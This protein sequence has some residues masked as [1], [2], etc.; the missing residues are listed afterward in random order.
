[1]CVIQ[2]GAVVLGP[3]KTPGFLSMMSTRADLKKFEIAPEHAVFD[4]DKKIAFA[5]KHNR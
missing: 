1:M 5:T 4:R 2:E 3:G